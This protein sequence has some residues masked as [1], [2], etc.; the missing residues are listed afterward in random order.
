MAP[1]VV[2]LSPDGHE[3]DHLVPSPGGR[4][5]LGI[6]GAPGAGKEVVGR[7]LHARSRRSQGPFVPVNCATMRPDRLE[8][9]LFGSEAGSNNEPR[10][11]GTFERA[12]GGTMFLDEIGTAS[13]PLQN[14]LLRVLETGE[15]QP[16]G[17]T[18]PEKCDVRI[19]KCDVRAL[20][21]RDEILFP[22]E[23]LYLAGIQ[24]WTSPAASSTSSLRV[25]DVP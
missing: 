21:L 19:V 25:C 3:L 22:R 4:F 13:L 6:S 10:K 1:E 15:I 16:V 14:A 7:L 24:R 20:L 5:L 23:Q 17:A 12:H 18:A 9:E 8:I 2:A 11:I